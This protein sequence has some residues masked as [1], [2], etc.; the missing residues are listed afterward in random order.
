MCIYMRLVAG[1]ERSEIYA[2][3]EPS[4]A[5]ALQVN[6]PPSR[7]LPM[8]SRSVIDVPSKSVCWK[9]SF[10]IV[11]MNIIVQIEMSLEMKVT[12]HVEI[13]ARNVRPIRSQNFEQSIRQCAWCHREV[14][15]VKRDCSNSIAINRVA[16][17]AGSKRASFTWRCVV[18]PLPGG[19][20]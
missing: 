5:V 15:L 20:S 10:K 6:S 14:V 11:G 3:K 1:K 9:T 12:V 17:E 8:P 16:I 4:K 13:I 19:M 18:G 2:P 7:T